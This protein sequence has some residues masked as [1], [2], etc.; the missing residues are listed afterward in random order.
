[1]CVCVW[2]HVC[3]WARVYVSMLN[4]KTRETRQRVASRAE[5]KEGVKI[6]PFYSTQLGHFSFLALETAQ[7][8]LPDTR[9]SARDLG[10]RLARGL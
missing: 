2:A 9:V 3:V 1:M 8:C 10:A 6:F 4:S 5:L 7:P